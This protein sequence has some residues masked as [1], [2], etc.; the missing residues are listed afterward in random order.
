MP[1]ILKTSMLNS[2]GKHPR[3]HMSMGPS[4]RRPCSNSSPDGRTTDPWLASAMQAAVLKTRPSVASRSRVSRRVKLDQVFPVQER[5]NRRFIETI[6]LFNFV[7]VLSLTY[8]PIL[9]SFPFFRSV[10][11]IVRFPITKESVASLIS[12]SLL[13]FEPTSFSSRF[14]RPLSA[15][16]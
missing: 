10:R 4:C 6:P 16:I 8:Q 2:L 9:I 1:V 14:I 11:H 3:T 7:Y 13:I 15:L 12:E 5:E